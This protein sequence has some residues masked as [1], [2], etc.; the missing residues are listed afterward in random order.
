M[1]TDAL[2]L[3]F[4]PLPEMNAILDTQDI[5]ETDILT[6]EQQ[7]SRRNMTTGTATLAS[8][9]NSSAT[10]ISL[11]RN[12]RSATSSTSKTYVTVHGDAATLFNS[13]PPLLSDHPVNRS[14]ENPFE[15]RTEYPLM[16]TNTAVSDIKALAKETSQLTSRSTGFAEDLRKKRSFKNLAGLLTRSAPPVQMHFGCELPPA[17]AARNV[18]YARA[19]DE[20]SPVTL[21]SAPPTS[22]SCQSR[23]KRMRKVSILFNKQPKDSDS[24]TKVPTVN[25]IPQPRKKPTNLP[26]PAQDKSGHVSVD[27][28]S[29]RTRQLPTSI[30][31]KSTKS[32]QQKLVSDFEAEE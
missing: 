16:T 29:L 6:D 15:I 25:Q 4:D 21:L 18:A 20:S 31:A 30:S 17:I 10:A 32:E 22:E 5:K 23:S 26:K 3:S 13:P 2:N 9:P 24:A 28:A 8:T 1:L 12:V 27:V 7:R 19:S 14:D 11:H